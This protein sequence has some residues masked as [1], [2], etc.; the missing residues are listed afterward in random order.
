MVEYK[1]PKLETRVRF[2]L[3]AFKEEDPLTICGTFTNS[4]Y[5][6]NHGVIGNV[7]CTGI[8]HHYVTSIAKNIKEPT[9][10]TIGK[11]L[12]DSIASFSPSSITVAYNG[13]ARTLTGTWSVTDLNGN[14]TTDLAGT[15]VG[16][17]D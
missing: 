15:I 7:T 14:P 2:P 11:S 10:A 4:G 12:D 5:I 8:T 3:S 1:L 16:K 13:T 17:N 6:E 9:T